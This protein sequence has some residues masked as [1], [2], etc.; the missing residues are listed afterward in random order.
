MGKRLTLGPRGAGDLVCVYLWSR[1]WSGNLARKESPSLGHFQRVTVCPPTQNTGACQGGWEAPPRGELE[2]GTSTNALVA[3]ASQASC[4]R[5][6][7]TCLPSP[8]VV[9][10][11][12]FPKTNRSHCYSVKGRTDSQ[13]NPDTTAPIQTWPTGTWYSRQWFGT[14]QGVWQSIRLWKQ[15][16]RGP[17]PEARVAPWEGDT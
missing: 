10:L 12:K 8:G 17:L 15:N 14:G 9:S 16:V 1:I 7:G 5:P 6:R 11:P 13:M 3:T 2:T 4:A